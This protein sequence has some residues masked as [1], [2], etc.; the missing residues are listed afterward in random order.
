MRF[1][2]KLA[3]GLLAAGLGL[4]FTGCRC[5][6]PPTD[7][8]VSDDDCI[9]FG[10][11]CEGASICAI[12]PFTG[13]GRCSS[14]GSPC[15]P[16]EV[17][18]ERARSCFTCAERPDAL[19]CRDG[20]LPPDG[21]L[22]CAERSPGTACFSEGV[23]GSSECQ[24]EDSFEWSSTVR[25]DGSPGRPLPITVFPGGYC[26]AGCT[27]TRLNDE[28][29]PCAACS[30][31]T[32]VGGLRLPLSYGSARYEATDGV[33]RELCAPSA[34]RSGCSREGYTCDLETSTCMEACVDDRQCQITLADV[35]GD[36]TQEIFDR[37]PDH[38]AYCDRTTGRCR[39]RGRPGARIG[40]PCREDRECTDDGVCLFATPTR[41]GICSRYGCRAEGFEC[42]AGSECDVRSVGWRRSACLPTC[43]IGLE[44]GT[45]AML[46]AGGGSP[47]CAPGQACIWNGVSEGADAAGSCVPAEYNGVRRSNVGAACREDG[48]CWSPFGY[49]LCLF[50]QSGLDTGICSVQSCATFLGPDDEPTEGLLP[51]VMIGSPICDPARNELCMSLG[52]RAQAP[53]TYC[54][55]RCSGAAD[56]P[57]RFACP[58]LLA[59]GNNFCW[60]TCFD[61]SECRPGASCEGPSGEACAPEDAVCLCSA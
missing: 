33:C 28:C 41:A 53:E 24:L 26:S 29:S 5:G 36:G 37:G 25:A 1:V 17:C 23:C 21:G 4:A 31:D 54:L 27:A 6:V 11:Y 9:D 14:E 52:S 48:D 46:G 3:F 42:P 49:G 20:G 22:A 13:A 45:R 47:D 60:P 2:S 35:D 34:D 58:E 50:R 30:G 39:M 32:L 55:L 61:S 15:R 10:V 7:G 38:P 8:C 51:G 57:A 59:G 44:D 18:D 56:C 16:G 43:R 12:D 40:D 19:E